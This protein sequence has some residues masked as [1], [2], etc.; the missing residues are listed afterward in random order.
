MLGGPKPAYS[1][2]T[3]ADSDAGA[4]RLGG[5]IVANEVNRRERT[6]AESQAN[7]FSPARVLFVGPNSAP[8]PDAIPPIAALAA[9]GVR[10]HPAPP[11]SLMFE[12]FSAKMRETRAYRGDVCEPS[13]PENAQMVSRCASL[14]F[15][16][17]GRV[18]RCRCLL[19]ANATSGR[20]PPI[21]R[22][23]RRAPRASDRRERWPEHRRLKRRHTS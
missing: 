16:L 23:M 18:I 21:S 6:R 15:S 11:T 8:N 10:I 22:A 7:K 12:A 5:R 2:P 3:G 13:A 14:R 19:L 17:C 4:R 9:P 1:A 20:E